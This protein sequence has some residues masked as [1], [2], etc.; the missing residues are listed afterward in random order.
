MSTFKLDSALLSQ[1]N[2]EMYSASTAIRT[3]IALLECLEKEGQNGIIVSKV[4]GHLKG[5]QLHS[6]AIV[7]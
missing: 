2:Q 4:I 1:V 6:L 7:G 5:V 3:S